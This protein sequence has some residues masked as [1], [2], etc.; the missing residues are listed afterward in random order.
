M[1]GFR[2]ECSFTLKIVSRLIRLVKIAEPGSFVPEPLLRFCRRS[3][4]DTGFSA[5]HLVCIAR[6]SN[7]RTISCG[8]D[9]G[10]FRAN[11]PRYSSQNLNL[12]AT[13]LPGF[14]RLQH[15]ER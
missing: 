9:A 14:E 11:A 10:I 6:F 15:G 3:L 1:L 5:R 8:T 12:A 13:C 2:D 7:R 4:H